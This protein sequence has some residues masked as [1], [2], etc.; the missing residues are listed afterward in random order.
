MTEG[1]A[2]RQ[3]AID[4]GR[5]LELGGGLPAVPGRRDAEGAHVQRGHVGHGPEAGLA[6]DLLERPFGFEDEPPRPLE[7]GAFDCRSDR[8]P[9]HR[10]E[11]LLQA[12]PRD[13]NRGGHL[14]HLDPLAR[15]LLN[16][17]HGLG[18][19]RVRDREHVGG[20]ASHDGHR[21]DVK[22][23]CRGLAPRRSSSNSV[24]AR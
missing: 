12:G 22:C 10:R 21:I 15:V 7:L 13:R 8:G 19:F 4:E 3:T 20:A 5:Q 2:D 14:G 18:H 24:A 11:S 6:R 16:E 23:P 1:C 17:R 9:E